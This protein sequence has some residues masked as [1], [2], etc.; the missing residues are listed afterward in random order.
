MLLTKQLDSGLG[1][2]GGIDPGREMRRIT[3][4]LIHSVRQFSL[5]VR[6]TG[7]QL[8]PRLHICEFDA[9]MALNV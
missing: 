5:I 6:C 1:S 4:T 7:R 3:K 2:N 9:P 8:Q